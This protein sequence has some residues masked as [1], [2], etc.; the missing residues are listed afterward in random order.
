MGSHSIF[1]KES[2]ESQQRLCHGYGLGKHFTINTI[3][4]GLEST[5]SRAQCLKV[6]F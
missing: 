6:T 5:T 2:L 1:I 3:R 4:K